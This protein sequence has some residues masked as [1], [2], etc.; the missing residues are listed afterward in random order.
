MR[1]TISIVFAACL[2]FAIQGP[3]AGAQATVNHAHCTAM[4]VTDST[5]S[6]QTSYSDGNTWQNVIDGSGTFTLSG[7]GCAVISFS[8]VV[9]ATTY[10]TD[11]EYLYLR[12]LVDGKSTCALAYAT[13][14][15]YS[16]DQGVNTSAVPASVTRVCE[17]LTAGTHT[18]QV[19]YEN[20]PS[21][22]GGD[23]EVL[24]P[25]LTVTHN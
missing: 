10:S 17:H 7:A 24:A 4:N 2:A 18:V 12:I 11:F 20:V 1:A 23:V 16:S 21:S 22:G 19:Q 15:L 6:D 9:V 8:A 3:F 14:L 25:T 13:Q 5:T